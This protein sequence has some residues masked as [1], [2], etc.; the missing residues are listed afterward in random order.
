LALDTRDNA[1][2]PKGG[3]HLTARGGIY[4]PIWDNASTFGELQG[5]ASTYLTARMPTE[6][7]LALRVGGNKLWGTFPFHEAAFLGGSNDLR[8]FLPQRFAGDGSAFGNA[9]LRFDMAG[10]NLLVPTRLGLFVAADIG[11]VFFDGDPAAADT[12]HTAF[13]GGVSMSV[14]DRLQ[15]FT[16]AIMT[17]DDL[18]GVYLSGG[19]PF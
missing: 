3:I 17:G 16:L 7:T 13:G 9:E 10:Y 14:I 12:W 18:T 2:N 1:G 6:P 15:T 19:F 5:S 4:P 11:R 8:G